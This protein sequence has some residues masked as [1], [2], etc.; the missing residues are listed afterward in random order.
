MSTLKG[1]Y[2]KILILQEL[3]K[4]HEGA[5]KGRRCKPFKNLLSYLEMVTGRVTEMFYDI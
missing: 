3:F 1:K 2:S 5:P 4:C